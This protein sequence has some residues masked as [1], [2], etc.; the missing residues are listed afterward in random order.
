MKLHLGC[1]PNIKEGYVNVDKFA[2]FPGVERW[3]ILD[4]PVADNS[5]DEVLNEHLAEHIPFKDEK[6]FW[7]ESFRVL[8]KGGVLT[9]ETP[10][11]EWLCEQ[12]LKAEDNF[13][14]FYSVGSP[15]HYFGSGKSIEN[16]WGMITTHFFGNQN[17][18]GQFHYNGYTKQKMIRIGEL[19][20][21]SKVEVE[22]LCNKGAHCIRGKFYK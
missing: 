16:R 21:F 20:G 15:D 17:G 13:Q 7:A 8:K 5:V 3:D 2:N 12:F 18:E 14:D 22:K 4:L 1:G 6:Q 10:D 9:V 19:I 11:M